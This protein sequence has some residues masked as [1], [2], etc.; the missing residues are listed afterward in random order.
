MKTIVLLTALALGATASPISGSPSIQGGIPQK[1]ADK[2]GVVYQYSDLPHDG[3]PHRLSMSNKSQEV[4][5]TVL[6]VCMPVFK[7]GWQGEYHLEQ[8]DPVGG[9]GVA[10]VCG[11]KAILKDGGVNKYVNKGVIFYLE[12]RPKADLRKIGTVSISVTDAEMLA[13]HIGECIRLAKAWNAPDGKVECYPRRVEVGKLTGAAGDTLTLAVDQSSQ[14]APAEVN[15]ESTN[16][17]VAV[18]TSRLEDVDILRRQMRRVHAWIEN[19][20]YTP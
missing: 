20:P 8:G 7:D 13:Q 5:I 14:N 1:V 10:A 9:V 12:V 19:R 2:P 3:K 16:N 15:F 17:N 11:S 6:M 4:D 18:Y